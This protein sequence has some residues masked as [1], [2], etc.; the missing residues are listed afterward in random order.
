M[1]V[2]QIGLHGQRQIMKLVYGGKCIYIPTF[3]I[4]FVCENFK[5]INPEASL[6]IENAAATSM[7]LAYLPVSDFFTSNIRRT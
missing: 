1:D 2:D 6:T 3:R 4:Q 7:F 5:R